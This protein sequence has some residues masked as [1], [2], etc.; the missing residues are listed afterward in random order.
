MTADG[1]LALMSA[2]KYRLF[3]A[4]DVPL[5][6]RQ[7]MLVKKRSVLDAVLEDAKSVQRGLSAADT[8]KLDEYFQGVRDIETRLAKEERWLGA[9]KPKT[10]LPQP[11]RSPGVTVPT[12]IRPATPKG[13]SCP[14]RAIR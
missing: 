5:E 9:A 3:S 6:Q 4:D 8:D 10:P 12:T 1:W 11:G 14:N 2:A 13:S 7:Q